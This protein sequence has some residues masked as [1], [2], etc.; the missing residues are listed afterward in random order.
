MVVGETHHVRKH[1]CKHQQENTKPLVFSHGNHP[2]LFPEKN[3]SK[4]PNA[5]LL[6]IQPT[7][8]PPI[9]SLS[10]AKAQHLLPPQKKGTEASNWDTNNGGPKTI[11]L[12]VVSTQLKNSS[13]IESFPQVGVK[14]KN[15]GNHHPVNHCFSSLSMDLFH[16]QG[17]FCCCWFFK[18]KKVWGI[19]CWPWKSLATFFC[20][21][22]SEPPLF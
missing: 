4:L 1:P 14:I 12:S 8:S 17:V 6:T 20:S 22:V 19:I 18:V 21:L 3:M 11:N 10:S 5:L 2:F 16:Q 9:H 15:I 7:P 13:Q